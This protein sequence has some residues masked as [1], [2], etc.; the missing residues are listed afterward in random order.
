MKFDKRALAIEHIKHMD[1]KGMEPTEIL[2]AVWI[3]CWDTSMDFFTRLVAASQE[4][5]PEFSGMEAA[6]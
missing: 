2:I 4:D 5:S 6:S 1:L 3:E